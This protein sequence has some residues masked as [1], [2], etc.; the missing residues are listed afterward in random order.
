MSDLT[1]SRENC[2]EKKYKV[3][4]KYNKYKWK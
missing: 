3:I 2:I 4:Y 1:R